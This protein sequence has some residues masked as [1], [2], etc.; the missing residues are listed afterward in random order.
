MQP[1]AHGEDS[2]ETV[3][4]TLTL[5]QAQEQLDVDPD[6]F[7]NICL[8]VEL[9]PDEVPLENIACLALTHKRL[10]AKSQNTTLDVEAD[11]FDLEAVY[12]KAATQNNVSTELT[13]KLWTQ[14]AAKNI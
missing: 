10:S 11:A 12:R 7:K 2:F 3:Y 9:L 5:T 6:F 1:Y 4:K 8:R 13:N 14:I